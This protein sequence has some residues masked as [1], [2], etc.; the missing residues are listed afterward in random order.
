MS[1]E[2]MYEQCSIC[3]DY[4]PEDSMEIGRNGKLTCI[5]CETFHKTPKHKGLFEFLGEIFKPKTVSHGC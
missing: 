1:K 5:V 4:F 2:I 3:R